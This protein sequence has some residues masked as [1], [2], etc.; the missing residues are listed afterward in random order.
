MYWNR[1]DSK[2]NACKE[3]QVTKEARILALCDPN[4]AYN[5]PLYNGPLPEGSK[6][7][8][9]GTTLSDFDEESIIEQ[10]PNV[11]FVSHPKSREPLVEILNKFPSLEWSECTTLV[12]CTYMDIACVCTECIFSSLTTMCVF[13]HVFIK[14]KQF[15]LA[16]L[17]LI[18][19]RPTAFLAL[20]HN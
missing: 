12:S 3:G 8:K 6:L 4:D 13:S 2:P 16:R 9:V 15:T 17:E 19:Y 11:I 20:K 5:K 14:K 18:L 10:K 7:L 1:E